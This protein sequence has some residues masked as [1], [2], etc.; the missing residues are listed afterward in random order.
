MKKI[1]YRVSV[2]LSHC[3]AL[4]ID[5]LQS[6]E[7]PRCLESD[8]EARFQVL[9]RILP[10]TALMTWPFLAGLPPKGLSDFGVIYRG[11]PRHTPEQY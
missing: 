6:E 4:V 5:P 10:P 8:R 1:A 9:Y 11:L 7:Y 2:F 3:G